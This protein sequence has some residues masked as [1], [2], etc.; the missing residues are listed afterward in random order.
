M[1]RTILSMGLFVCVAIGANAQKTTTPNPV[2]P[3][4]AKFKFESEVIDYGIIEHNANGNREFI[5][6]NVGKEPLIITPVISSCGCLVASAPKEPIA[7]GNS[8][9]IKIHY[10]TSRIGAFEKTVTVKSNDTERPSI[11]LKIKGVVKADPTKAI[12]VDQK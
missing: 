6:T 1:R 5:F 8:A 11:V 4:A 10:D 2:N 7:P 12:S 9:V 3:N